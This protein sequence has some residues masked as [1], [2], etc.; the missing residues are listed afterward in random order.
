MDIPKL[1]FE[2]AI[3]MSR[4]D[5]FHRDWRGFMRLGEPPLSMTGFTRIEGLTVRDTYLTIQ[6]V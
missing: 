2:R 1:G 5:H 3:D 6:N 4:R